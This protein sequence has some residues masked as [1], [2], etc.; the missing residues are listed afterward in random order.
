MRTVCS[1]SYREVL[2]D[3]PV[4]IRD[5]VL[6][7]VFLCVIPADGIEAVIDLE[8]H[9]REGPDCWE[10]TGS[11]NRLVGCIE[12]ESGV[13]SVGFVEASKDQDGGGP[14]LEGH[15]QVAGD[16]VVLVLERDDFP[17]VLLDVVEFADV[18]DLLGRELDAPREDVDE[19]V[20]ENAAGCGVAG[21]IELCHAHP[22]VN[23]HV[24][25]LTA[26]V[27]V[28]RIIA[29]NDV[30]AVSLAFVDGGEVRARLVELGSMLK[31]AVLLNV[32][33]HPVAAHVVLVAPCDAEKP[34]VVCHDSATELG[35]VGLEVDQ[36]LALLARV[37]IVEVDVLVAPLEVVDYPLVRQLLLQDEDVLK[38][39][40]DALLDVEMIEFG[41]HGL[42]VLEVPFVLVDQGVALVDHAPDVVKHSGIGVACALLKAC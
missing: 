9:G 5:V 8:H 25:V 39:L 18:G 34:P 28:L 14:D 15:G 40:K 7:E 20:V 35:N 27:E 29:A 2:V 11:L 12:D 41:D 4:R 6:I 38:E 31:A 22:A 10:V 26:A 16:P 32:L 42:L 1:H 19:L 13:G 37:H 33:E 3:S 36:V 24:V 17:D 21:H 30:D 23:C